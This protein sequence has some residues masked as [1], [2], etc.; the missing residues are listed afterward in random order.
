MESNWNRSARRSGGDRR[1]QINT[2]R[3]DKDDLQ[4][5]A[6]LVELDRT[7]KENNVSLDGLIQKARDA[8][9]IECSDE[10]AKILPTLLC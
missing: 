6:Y 9:Y 4:L 5:L 1:F 10:E 8:G 3:L 2:P 7:A